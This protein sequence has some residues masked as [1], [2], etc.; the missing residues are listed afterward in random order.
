MTDTTRVALVSGASRN[1]GLGIATRFSEM[2]MRVIAT[3]RNSDDLHAAYAG[4]GQSGVDCIPAD[5]NS[6]E[7]IARLVD[8][9][10][11]RYGRVDI[12]INLAVQRTTHKFDEHPLDEFRTAIQVSLVSAFQLMQAF[13]PRMVESGWGRVINFGGLSGQVGAANRSS[14]SAT[15]AGLAGLSRTIALEVAERG[16]TVNTVSPGP[17][18]TSRGEWTTSGDTSALSALY[19]D[20]RKLIPVGQRGSIDDVVALCEYLI[21]DR[22]AYMTGQNIQLNGGLYMA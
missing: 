17:I 20:R 6:D 7:S 15:K 13:V 8:T 3:A 11:N 21:S 2:G 16:V 19:E 1:I 10:H 22:A 4:R 18:E 5:M 14:V 12:L 9:V